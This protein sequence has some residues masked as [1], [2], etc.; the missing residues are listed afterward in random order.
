MTLGPKSSEK[1]QWALLCQHQT[2]LS[3][4]K[5]TFIQML[6]IEK[7]EDNFSW[8]LMSYHFRNQEILHGYPRSLSKDADRTCGSWKEEILILEEWQSCDDQCLKSL[9]DLLHS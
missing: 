9:F 6:S 4:T 8:A 7:Y 5:I 1:L 3:T 2:K